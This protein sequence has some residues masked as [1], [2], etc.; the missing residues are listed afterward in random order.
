VGELLVLLLEVPVVQDLDL[1][2]SLAQEVHATPAHLWVGVQ[3]T[4]NYSPHPG[5]QDSLRAWGRPA[6]VVAG[7]E[8]NVQLGPLGGRPA[9][10]QGRDFRVLFPGAG[11][12]A[13]ADH[14][15][16]AY[17][18]RPNQWIGCSRVAP[19]LRKRVGALHENVTNQ[20]LPFSHPDS[21][22]RRRN[23]VR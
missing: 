23:T 16:I 9:V 10:V 3:V 2:A 8:C 14:R 21:N 20:R 22:R 12:P 6:V 5:T 19:V 17:D 4:G 13:F 1:D 11:V 18:E 15:A 7:L